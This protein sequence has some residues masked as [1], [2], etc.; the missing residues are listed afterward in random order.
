MKQGS[1]ARNVTLDT[2]GHGP[3]PDDCPA[4]PVGRGAWKLRQ[5]GETG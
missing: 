5:R 4:R 3:S 1:V 2:A